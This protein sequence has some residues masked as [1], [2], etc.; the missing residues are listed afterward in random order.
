LSAGDIHQ[1]ESN[2]LPKVFLANNI[3]EHHLISG[4]FYEVKEIS[5]ES[6]QSGNGNELIYRFQAIRLIGE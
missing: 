2:G 6:N 3:Y 1:C 5:R 4:G